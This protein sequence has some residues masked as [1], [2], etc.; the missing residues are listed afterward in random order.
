M[1]YF[2]SHTKS[3]LGESAQTLQLP[4]FGTLQTN[5]GSQPQVPRFDLRAGETG[6]VLVGGGQTETDV[7]TVGPGTVTVTG[8][9]TVVV[10]SVTVGPGMTDVMV[11]PSSV[12]VTVI[13][14]R[15]VV[16]VVTTVEAGSVV[17][18]VMVSVTVSVRV[19]GTVVGA[20]VGTV[21]GMVVGTTVTTV[22]TFH[23]S[24]D[25][26]PSSFAHTQRLT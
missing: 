6:A 10:V 1:Q 7:I 14:G 3:S 8:G 9:T 21:I 18:L 26:E 15:T 16:I 17:R 2:G 5:P 24:A 19:V 11:V 25:Q 4:G 20:V 22:V 13:G 12:T 23:K